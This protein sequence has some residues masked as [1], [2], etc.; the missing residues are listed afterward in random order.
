MYAKFR[1]DIWLNIKVSHT[2]SFFIVCLT[3][4]CYIFPISAIPTD[5]LLLERRGRVP[6]FR[7]QI[8]ILIDRRTW[9]NH[10]CWSYVHTYIHF[11][12]SPLYLSGGY[13]VFRM[14]GI[15]VIVFPLYST[16]YSQ[17]TWFSSSYI[18]WVYFCMSHTIRQFSSR[19]CWFV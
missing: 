16:L 13:V 15:S 17:S 6:N 11:V 5:G 12:G 4:I 14:H 7:S 10:W 18:A 19:Y 8:H 9:L 2:N 3:A 1:K